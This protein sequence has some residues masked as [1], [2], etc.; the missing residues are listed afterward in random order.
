M[1]KLK[2]VAERLLAPS[3]ICSMI[4][5]CS[6]V[7]MQYTHS[8][9]TLMNLQVLTGIFLLLALASVFIILKHDE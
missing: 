5:Y 9:S 3:M 1:K 7:F 4:T 2:L 8:S 6:Y